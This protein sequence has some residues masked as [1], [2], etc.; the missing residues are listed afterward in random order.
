MTTRRKSASVADAIMRPAIQQDKSRKNGRPN[1]VLQ[2]YSFISLLSDMVGAQLRSSINGFHWWA[3]R[4]Y[5]SLQS[6]LVTYLSPISSFPRHISTDRF[7]KVQIGTSGTPNIKPLL[8]AFVSARTMSSP[9]VAIVIY[10]MYGHIAKREG[11]DT[12]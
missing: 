5:D 10:S 8:V 12:S 2:I 9:K 4:M 7:R 3:D 1:T 6:P 11:S